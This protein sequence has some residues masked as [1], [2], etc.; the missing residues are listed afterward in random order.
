M[1]VI[2][3]FEL[4]ITFTFKCVYFMSKC[5]GG[6]WS[7]FCLPQGMATWEAKLGEFDCSPQAQDWGGGGCVV[8][9]S[10][11]QTP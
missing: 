6:C 2:S 1:H 7:A 9:V 11:S 8:C 5:P 10:A 4:K 3:H